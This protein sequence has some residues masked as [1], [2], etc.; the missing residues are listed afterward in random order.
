ML[1]FNQLRI[2]YHAAKNLNFT[3]AAKDLFITQPAVTAQI[4]LLEEHC[5]MKLFRKK[6]RGVH[7]TDEGRTLFEYT[8]HVFDYE[9][10][11]EFVIEEMQEL[12]RGVL[13]LG[14][15]K[16]YARYFM[17]FLLTRFHQAYSDIRISLDEGSSQSMV[18]SLVDFKNEV[19]IIAKIVSHP[20]VQFLPLSREEIVVIAHPDHPLAARPDISVEELARERIIMKEGGSGTRH[21]VDRM[22]A[23]NNITPNIVMETS[24][25][26]FIKME[27]QRGEGIAFLVESAVLMELENGL[28][29]SLSIDDRTLFLDV[30]IAYL[31]DQQLSPPARAFLENLSDLNGG[32]MP[33]MGIGALMAKI[34]GQQKEMTAS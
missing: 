17:P 12:K 33:A 10:E 5:E 16:T 13:R 23:R 34:R 8:K 21:L 31:K 22:F 20:D 6:G 4:K 25:T 29:T 30:S 26:E 19:V 2:F 14:T 27:V 15:T 3:A 11:I 32:D 18:Q 1:N 24:N 9:K 28:L 7:L